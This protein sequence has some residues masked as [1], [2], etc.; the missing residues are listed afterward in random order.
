MVVAALEGAVGLMALL[1]FE[2]LEKFAK[3]KGSEQISACFL[4]TLHA[5]YYN[6]QMVQIM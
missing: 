4:L 5:N 1:G 6:I 3:L 2:N